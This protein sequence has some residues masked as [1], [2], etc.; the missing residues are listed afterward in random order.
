LSFST[1]KDVRE[2]GEN[3]G[4]GDQAGHVGVEDD[5]DRPIDVFVGQDEQVFYSPGFAVN[6]HLGQSINH[7]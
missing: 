6:N 4:A 3:K 1:P 7:G 5:L 2:G